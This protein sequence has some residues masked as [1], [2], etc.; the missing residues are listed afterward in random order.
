MTPYY[1]DDLVTIYHGRAEDILATPE[2][3]Q[4]VDVLLTDPPYG[5][6]WDCDYRRFTQG[7]SGKRQG[8]PSFRA[9]PAVQGDKQPFNPK[10]W[11]SFPTVILWGAN[12]FLSGLG[13]GSL[14]VWYKRD[15][16]FLAQGEAA[17]MNRGKAVYVYKE[18]V[19]KM[20]RER[21]HPTQKPISLMVWCLEKAGGSGTVLDPF[22]GSGTTL[23]AA[24]SLGR[25]SIG[26]EI[27]ELYC[28]IAANRCRQEVLG[29]SA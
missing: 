26:I 8:G 23:V 17:W 11:L 20:Q 19:E 25:K 18:P 5:I 4:G 22:M 15:R 3:M 14:L 9:Y 7:P 21:V 2:R 29:L 13:E 6:D 1:S 27:E 16:D 12:C 24:K 28:E 10:P